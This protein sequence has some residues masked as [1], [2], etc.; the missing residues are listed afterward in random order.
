MKFL[1]KD[2]EQIIYEADK[3]VLEKRGLYINGKMFK[4]LRIGNYGIADLVTVVR[5]YN[6]IYNDSGKDFIRPYL[7]INVYELKKDKIGI[8]AF[9]QAVRYVKGIKRYLSKR[10]FYNYDFHITLIGSDLDT[11]GSFCFLSDLINSYSEC[12]QTSIT[13]I[14]FKT[15]SFELEGLK[16]KNESSYSLIEE[17]FWYE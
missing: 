1:E 2:L 3:D 5:D 10:N 15:Y 6:Y 8:S 17:G 14:R 4:Q 7:I 11:S 12:P 9:L 16:F 13:G